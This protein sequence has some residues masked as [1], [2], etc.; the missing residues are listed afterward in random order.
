MWADRQIGRRSDCI[1]ARFALLSGDPS[2]GG[3]LPVWRPEPAPPG[4]TD[5]HVDLAMGAVADA[6]SELL[7]EATVIAAIVVRAFGPEVGLFYT[8]LQ[9]VG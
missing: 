5:Y 8:R 1:P 9:L 4:T 2:G 6:L 3:R 7:V